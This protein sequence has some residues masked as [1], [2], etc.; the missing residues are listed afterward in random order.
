MRVSLFAT[1]LADT[2]FPGVARST[3]EVIE[4][5]GHEV[6]FP[7][8]QTCC[9]QMHANSG[10]EAQATELA[11]RFVRVFGERDAIVSPSAS[12][13]GSV[14]HQYK[15]LAVASGDQGLVEEVELLSARVFEFTEFIVDELGLT[16]VGAS[17][18]HRVTYHPT[19]HSTRMLG[20]GDRPLRLLNEVRGLDLVDLPEQDQCCG[21]GGTFAVK[22]SET[23][24]A[25]LA[26]KISA[27]ESTGAEY[28][29]A[30]DASCLM[31]IGGGLTRADTP[32][33]TLHLAQ[34][35]GHAE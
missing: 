1:C 4:R 16:D 6:E 26:D 34:I 21:F 10:Y 24:S 31:Q 7:A 14:R 33:K 23:S 11:R 5:L 12:C 18:P 3:V 28:C 2:L 32:V 27:I 9:G 19:C 25:M 17:F 15:R 13:V 20:I 8:E 29:V 35:L 22:N 30:A